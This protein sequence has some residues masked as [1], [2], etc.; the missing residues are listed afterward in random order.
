MATRPRGATFSANER[1]AMPLPRT[2][3]S[4]LLSISFR[5]EQ[6]VR[7]H[8]NPLPQETGKTAACSQLVAGRARCSQ[9]CVINQPRVA[10][11]YGQRHLRAAA[12]GRGWLKRIGVE[13]LDVIDFG[14][15][16]LL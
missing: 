11:K 5:L 15:R 3:K 4:K 1:P 13:K 10:D 8:P 2:T 7:P 9:G 12:D 16:L 14:V 6:K